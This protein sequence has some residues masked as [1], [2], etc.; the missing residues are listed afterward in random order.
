[1]TFCGI[2]SDN[3]DVQPLNASLLIVEIF[4]GIF[5][6]VNDLQSLANEWLI[7]V[8]FEGIVKFSNE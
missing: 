2:V 3:K 6:V 7:T 4:S 1:M 5:I 8:W